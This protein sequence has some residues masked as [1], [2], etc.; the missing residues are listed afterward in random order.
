MNEGAGPSA[1]VEEIRR[2][3]CDTF[4]LDAADLDATTR[5]DDVGVN[6]RQRVRL[7]ATVETHFGVILD[8]DQLERLTDVAGVASVIADA[9]AAGPAGT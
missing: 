1:Y 5:F 2:I 6:S 3:V 4:H 7:L 9:R 8:V